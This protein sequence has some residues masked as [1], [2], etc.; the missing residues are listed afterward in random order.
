MRRI[1]VALVASAAA[2]C[3]G[4]PALSP[5]DVAAHADIAARCEALFPRVPWQATQVLDA[6]MP[7]GNEGS[8]LAVVSAEAPGKFRSILISVEGLVLYDATYSYGRIVVNRAVPPLDKPSFARGMSAD[9]RLLMFRPAT[10][11]HEVGLDAQGR[12]TCRWERPD[13]KVIEAVLESAE[14]V[15]LRLYS[16]SDVVERDAVLAGPQKSGL[17]QNMVLVAPGTVGYSLH[18]RLVDGGPITD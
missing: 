7:M 8:F 5:V 10:P 18:L 4:L 13:G 1:G 15:A 6:T 16:T 17:F 14:R 2:A 9:I 12:R 11:L 3:G